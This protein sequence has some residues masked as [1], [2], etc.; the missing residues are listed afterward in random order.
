MKEDSNKKEKEKWQK[1]IKRDVS[2]TNSSNKE[3]KKQTD[4]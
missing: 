4:D 1:I 2:M 3:C